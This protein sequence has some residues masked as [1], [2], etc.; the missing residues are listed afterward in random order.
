MDK[1]LEQLA[2]SGPLGI[3]AALAIWVAWK[4]DQ[5]LKSVNALL[6]TKTELFLD[7]YHKL[8]Y[9]LKLTLKSWVDSV[10]PEDDDSDP[11]QE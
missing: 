6:L 1:L 2:A 3:I 11:E 5:E 4:K 7:R 10:E 9:E 8:G